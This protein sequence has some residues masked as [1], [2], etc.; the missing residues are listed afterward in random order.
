[1]TVE[2]GV[3]G[4]IP[5]L[6]TPQ[7]RT[8]VRHIRWISVL[9]AVAGLVLVAASLALSLEPLWVLV[10]LLLFW[11]GIVKVIV[12]A[13]WRNLGGSDAPAAGER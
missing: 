3:A 5:R 9:M 10:G 2:P 12:V 4:R 8:R 7:S 11:A 1:M 6:P 13:L